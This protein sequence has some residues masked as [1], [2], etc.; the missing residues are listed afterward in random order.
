MDCSLPGSSVHGILQARI[1]EWV[2]FPSQGDLSD[3][4]IEPT[5]LMSPALADGFFITSETLEAPSWGIHIQILIVLAKTITERVQQ[6]KVWMAPSSWLIDW[7]MS[8]ELLPLDH[9]TRTV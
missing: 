9:L 6:G 1:L 8:F 7:V 2:A 3:P 5:S 4:R